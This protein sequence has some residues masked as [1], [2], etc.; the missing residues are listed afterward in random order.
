MMSLSCEADAGCIWRATMANGM[1]KYLQR[2]SDHMAVS[3][4][5]NQRQSTED[6]H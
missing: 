4:Q 3:L 5:C 1:V 6:L 2:Y